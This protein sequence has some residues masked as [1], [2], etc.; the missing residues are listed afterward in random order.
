MIVSFLLDFLRLLSFE[1]VGFSL[2]QTDQRRVESFSEYDKSFRLGWSF[3]SMLFLS[4]VC[5]FY[6]GKYFLEISFEYS[7]MLAAAFLYGTLMIEV[8]LHM[9]RT[10][11]MS[12]QERKVKE[13]ISK[14][15]AVNTKKKR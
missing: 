14:S 3:I 15:E 2:D 7:L 11:K 10:E 4:G 1:L 8:F 9:A 12:I 13:A 6:F 5:G